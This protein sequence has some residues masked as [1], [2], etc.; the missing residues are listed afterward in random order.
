ME[1]SQWLA[2]YHAVALSAA[3]KERN[4]W[5]LLVGGVI[6]QSILGIAA[7]F[8]ALIE[9]T[10]FVGVSF[11]IIIALSSVGFITATGWTSLLARLQSEALHFDA[12]SR[13]IESQFAGAE[14]FRSLHR[15]SA[16][17]KVCTPAS[18]W[19]CNDWLPSV[20]RLP[21]GSRLLPEWIGSR[22]LTW[23]FLLGWV[24]LLVY[25]LTA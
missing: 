7:G 22:L 19:S 21:L 18:D 15:L 6:M 12:L 11:V 10:P 1:L 2:I 9:P 5:T 17:E 13:G 23:P 16:G 4:R 3:S 14:F 24:G 8:F 20:S 25:T